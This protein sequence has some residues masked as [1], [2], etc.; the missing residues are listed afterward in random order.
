MAQMKLY[1]KPG[2]PWCS[3][4]LRY[5]DEQGFSYDAQN[6]L[7]DDNAYQRMREISGQSRTPTMEVDGQVLA[8]FGVDELKPFLARHEIRP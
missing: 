4:A 5:L 6:V 7:T 2:C 8:D 3:E 1:I